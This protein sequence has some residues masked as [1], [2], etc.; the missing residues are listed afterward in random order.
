MLPDRIVTFRRV[1]FAEALRS[2]TASEFRLLTLLGLRACPRT[3]RVW[4][5]PLRLAEEFS[6]SPE[7]CAAA[8]IDAM[9]DVLVAR[10]H[11]TLHARSLGALRC[12][13]VGV[14]VVRHPD[15]P[16]ANLPVLP[17]L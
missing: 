14:T 3:K 2:L 15:E 16:P 4:T 17:D 8:V 12:Y 5:T 9:L 7:T 10:G 1:P 11:I 13:E 6:A